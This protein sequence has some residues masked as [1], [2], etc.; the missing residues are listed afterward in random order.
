MAHMAVRADFAPLT[1]MTTA[2]PGVA[3][4][5]SGPPMTGPDT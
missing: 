5:L 3:H 2:P 4:A 1:E